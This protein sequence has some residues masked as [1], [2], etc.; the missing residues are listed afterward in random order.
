MEQW[1]LRCSSVRTKHMMLPTP[2]CVYCWTTVLTV[3]LLSSRSHQFHRRL[4]SLYFSSDITLSSKFPIAIVSNMFQLSCSILLYTSHA[5]HYL[6][7]HLPNTLLSSNSPNFFIL[8]GKQRNRVLL[9]DVSALFIKVI[10][11]IKNDQ[12]TQKETISCCWS[13]IPKF[14]RSSKSKKMLAESAF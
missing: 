3:C 10:N 14:G 12:L 7:S 6:I 8:L 4:L 13:K 11:I 2:S 5:L 1:V 9:I